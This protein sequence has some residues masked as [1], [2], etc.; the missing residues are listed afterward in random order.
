MPFITLA[1]CL[2]EADKGA[3]G[4]GAFNVNNMEQIQSIMRAAKELNSPVI[5]QASRGALKYTNKLYLKH[6]IK[7][8]VEENPDIPVVVH[9][10][11]GDSL[12]TV[13]IAVS[14]G[15]TSVMIDGS[16][17]PFAE[18]VALT[19]QV[20]DYAH[21]FGV[22]VE[23]EL[24]TLGGIEEDIK[25]E[26]RLTDPDQAKEFVAKTQCDALAVA[27]GTSHGAY[28]FKAEPK[29]AIDLITEI[30]KDVN[31][32]LVLHGSSS[33]PQQLVEKV[34]RYGGDME[35]SVGVPIASLQEA[36]KRG[37][38]KINVDTDLRLAMTASIREVFATNPKA[39]DPRDYLTPAKESVY[40]VVKS[41]MIDFGSAGHAQDYQ[42]ISLEEM[43]KNYNG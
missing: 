22:S 27:I 1:Q 3:Y 8:A 24:G 36:I 4:V 9:L 42:A 2:N 21:Q 43:I 41:K 7:A 26:V 18:N 12:D 25:G 16:H 20:V 19:K 39:F 33:V 37:V 38:R 15:F 28:K 17:L 40:E 35:N 34:N 32:P 6:L 13:K 29:L 11:H 23:A 14:L 30:K 10:D 31:I 5:M